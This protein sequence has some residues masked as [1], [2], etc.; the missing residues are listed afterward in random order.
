MNPLVIFDIDGTLCD[1]SDVDGECF[2]KVMSRL[3][4]VPITPL[5]WRGVPHVTDAGIAD[6]LWNRYLHRSPDAGEWEAIVTAYESELRRELE[7]APQRFSAIKG[8]PEI[9][10]RLI[11]DGWNIAISTGGWRRTASLKLSTANIPLELLVATCDDSI[12]RFEIFRL[13]RDRSFEKLKEPLEKTVIVGD[14]P[15]DVRVAAFHR[16]GFLGI[17]KGKNAERLLAAGASVV[18]EDYSD[19]KRVVDLLKNCSMPK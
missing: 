6:M 9:L 14:G 19:Q 1:T 16:W 5:S 18:V 4:D 11:A 7:A 15:W 8:A 13:A 17:G 12:D 2:S 3:L 10:E